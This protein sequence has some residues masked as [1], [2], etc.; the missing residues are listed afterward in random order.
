MTSYTEQLTYIA[1]N[2]AS[3][4]IETVCL[5]K[6]IMNRS[7]I[8]EFYSTLLKIQSDLL[9]ACYE[10]SKEKDIDMKGRVSKLKK[11]MGFILIIS[12]FGLVCTVS[13][14]CGRAL[15]ANFESKKVAIFFVLSVY[16]SIMYH[17]RLLTF[18][19]WIC[20]IMCFEISFKALETL[21]RPRDVKKISARSTWIMK[22]YK[23]LEESLKE[24]HHL[25]GSQLLS[26]CSL[27][28]LAV[29]N[30]SYEL[31]KVLRTEELGC[32]DFLSAILAVF[33]LTLLSIAFFSLCNASSEMTNQATNCALDFRNISVFSELRNDTYNEIL[34]FY[35]S[36][37]SKPPRIS[38]GNFFSLGRHI[39]PPV[40]GLMTTYLIVLQQFT[41]QEESDRLRGEP[42]F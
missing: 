40:L 4:F 25:F 39:L 5:V 20:T 6:F 35:I 34:L 2:R 8:Q 33:Q 42:S 30:T 41:L 32:Y 23:R 10:N 27:F 7:K 16:W 31:L 11:T 22:N 3:T 12:F 18:Y 28:G 21:V 26:I 13:L 1:V 29:L 19:L 9:E 15:E 17:F 38:P 14:H 37:I 24:F 36:A